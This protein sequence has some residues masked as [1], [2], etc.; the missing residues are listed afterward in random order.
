MNET[1]T[2][3]GGVIQEDWHRLYYQWQHTGMAPEGRR[4]VGRLRQRWV[5][6]PNPWKWRRRIIK[7]IK[8]MILSEQ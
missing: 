5:D 3:F 4:D 1:I 6:G 2:G 7:Q 8:C